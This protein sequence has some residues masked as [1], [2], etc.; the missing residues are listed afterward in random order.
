MPSVQF[1]LLA[2]ALL[3]ISCIITQFIPQA[4][5]ASTFLNS[6]LF[7]TSSDGLYP[8]KAIAGNPRITVN[9]ANVKYV[10]ELTTEGFSQLRALTSDKQLQSLTIASGGGEVSI[11]IDFGVWVFVNKL[12]V[13]VEKACLSSCANYVFP[14]GRKKIIL[15]G[16]VVAWHGS[17]LQRNFQTESQLR[18]QI[19]NSYKRM[20]KRVSEAEIERDVKQMMSDMAVIKEKQK[21]F[22]QKI[23][24][25][26]YVTRIGN[27]EYGARGFYFLSVEDMEKFGIMNVTAP[28]NY[29]KTDLSELNSLIPVPIV[30]IKLR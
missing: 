17:I 16:A 10:G 24:V 14:A 15:P 21:A 18:E 27:E 19:K 4:F 25:N 12:D 30:Y 9:D 3:L 22:Y 8:I 2:R 29:P 23:G 13:I 11:S 7:I 5:A 26:E 1:T 28:Q 20:K 6:K